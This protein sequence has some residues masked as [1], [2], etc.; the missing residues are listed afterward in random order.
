[1]YLVQFD[2]IN[3][4]EIEVI[5]K[6]ILAVK[7]R[8]AIKSSVI[9]QNFKKMSI[10]SINSEVFQVICEYMDVKDA[11][12]CCIATKYVNGCHFF[13]VLFSCSDNQSF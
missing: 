11:M 8:N 12:N 3:Q 1:M 2:H 4:N 9:R 5:E 10:L 7:V 13:V 6:V